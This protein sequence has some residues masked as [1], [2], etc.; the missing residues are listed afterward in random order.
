MLG[1]IH[2][3]RWINNANRRDAFFWLSLSN[4]EYNPD[5]KENSFLLGELYFEGGD[6]IE[7]NYSLAY[8]WL[9]N[10]FPARTD[11]DLL[12]GLMNKASAG[13]CPERTKDDLEGAFQH[14]EKAADNHN[15]EAMIELANM[16][17]F[18]I[19]VEKNKEKSKQLMQEVFWQ[20]T[21]SREFGQPIFPDSY[22]EGVEDYTIYIMPSFEQDK[23]VMIKVFSKDGHQYMK[24]KFLY[25]KESAPQEISSKKWKELLARLDKINFWEMRYDDKV[26]GLD[27]TPILIE[28]IQKERYHAVERN[29]SWQEISA[30]TEYM[31]ELAGVGRHTKPSK[32]K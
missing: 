19:S 18:G 14:F 17:F 10:A 28:G 32:E 15:N 25:Q 6:G 26:M 20:K 3:L 21:V 16:Y 11:A 5:Y 4:H 30:V 29:G 2:A 12:L 8:A 27:G 1:R 22:Q 23:N 9:G 7:K 31:E 13:Q 24:T